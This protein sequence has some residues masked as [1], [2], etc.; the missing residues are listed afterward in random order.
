MKR[1]LFALML[2]AGFAGACQTGGERGEAD[3]SAMDEA[4]PMDTSA[5][6]PTTDTIGMGADTMAADTAAMGT[7]TMRMDTT[8]PQP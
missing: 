4:A 5:M 7:D 6:A 1:K 3:Q 2:L 8:A